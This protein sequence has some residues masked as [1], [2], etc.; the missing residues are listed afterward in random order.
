MLFINK[1]TKNL[2]Y[3]EENI[4]KCNYCNFKLFYIN[5]F[6]EHKCPM[7]NE[8]TFIIDENVIK[9]KQSNFLCN[10][11]QIENKC[12]KHNEEFLY[13]KDSNYYCKKC[14]EEKN[15]ENYVNLNE[16]ILSKEEE[17]NFK[18][19]LDEIKKNY[20]EIK[21][22]YL[23]YIDSL[24]EKF[25]NFEIKSNSLIEYFENLIKLNEK[26]KLNY[27]LISTIRRIS[28]DFNINDLKKKLN[29]NKLNFFDRINIISFNNNFEEYFSSEKIL[30]GGKYYHLK[31][32]FNEGS[33]GKIYKG[34][35]IKD[36]K[37]VAIK[38]IDNSTDKEYF[39]TINLY[40]LKKINNCDYCV[41]FYDLFEEKNKKFI[42]SEFFDDNL[43]I[44]F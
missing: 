7:K 31:D 1:Y 25:K 20:N 26:Y 37:F 11:N 33:F 34:L 8:E 29:T 42:V 16:I 30:K 21:Q 2:I 35:S 5:Q 36:K 38:E 15:L 22:L 43:K 40:L 39:N 6:Y 17:N 44:K 28:I 19:L 13:Y 41:N 18:I 3:D 12:V 23:K 9:D 14:I 10:V 4:I 24:K 27:N 32:I